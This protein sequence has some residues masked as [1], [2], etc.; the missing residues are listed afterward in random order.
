MSDSK[1]VLKK[2]PVSNSGVTAKQLSFWNAHYGWGDYR[3]IKD[4]TNLS[5]PTIKDA[6]DGNATS[7]VAEKIT[8]YYLE[9]SAQ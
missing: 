1:K 2:R 6:F 5:R 7:D 8:N 4:K 9:K 3:K